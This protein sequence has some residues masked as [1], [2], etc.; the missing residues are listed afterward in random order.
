VPQVPVYPPDTGRAADS[1]PSTGRSGAAGRSRAAGP[2]RTAACSQDP[3][4]QTGPCSRLSTA[5]LA[6]FF[7]S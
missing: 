4:F 3:T 5:C 1:G 6:P 2:G 7:H